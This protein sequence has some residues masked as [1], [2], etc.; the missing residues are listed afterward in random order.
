MSTRSRS[1]R[2]TLPKATNSDLKN[3]TKLAKQQALKL[4]IGEFTTKKLVGYLN[5]PNAVIQPTKFHSG[6]KWEAV[7]KREIERL[8]KLANEAKEEKMK[9]KEEKMKAKEE[10]RKA[11]KMEAELKA[12]VIAKLR[13]KGKYVS[14]DEDSEKSDE[15]EDIDKKESSDSDSDV[16]DKSGSDVE[17][18]S[19]PINIDAVLDEIVAN[20]F[21]SKGKLLYTTREFD[22]KRSVRWE[23]YTPIYD[24]FARFLKEYTN[25]FNVYTVR[26]KHEDV[27]VVTFDL[28]AAKSTAKTAE[29][30]NAFTREICSKTATGRWICLDDGPGVFKKPD[31][32]SDLNVKSI[33]PLPVTGDDPTFVFEEPYEL[34]ISDNEDEQEVMYN[35][36]QSK[37]NQKVAK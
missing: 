2:F 37:M 6:A 21:E 19:P 36:W 8:E 10:K 35:Q 7:T 17:D 34:A 26:M 32:L 4:F 20:P 1:W 28:I 12:K 24:V 15:S 33:C 5:Y 11:K 29:A 25:A 22:S 3:I 9:A 31:H 13:A 14:E 18:E 16:E 23:T 30:H 27:H